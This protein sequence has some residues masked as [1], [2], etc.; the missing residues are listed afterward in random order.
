MAREAAG[1]S[2]P[3]LLIHSCSV[4][5]LGRKHGFFMAPVSLLVAMVLGLGAAA[6][7]AGKGEKLPERYRQWLVRDV[8]YIIT[9]EEKDAFLKLAGDEDREK[10][11][12]R[13]WDI[14]NPMPGSPYNSYKEEHYQ[15]IAYADQ[16]FGHEAGLEGW[17]TDRGRVYITLGPPQQTAYYTSL[18]KLRPVEI[19][20]YS[21]SHPSLPPFF[22]VMF[23]QRENIGDFRMYSPYFDGPEKLI[24]TGRAINDRV[25]ALHF[26][27]EAAGREVARIS[28]S[29]IPDEPADLK[30]ATSSL[31]SDVLLSTIRNLAN[32]PLEKAELER[33]RQL[34]ESVST[35][36]ILEGQ[37]LDVLTVPLRDS[38][39]LTRCHYLL[40]LRNPQDLSVG[41]TNDGRYSFSIE[42]RVRVFGP[43]NKLIFAQ[44]KSLSQTFDRS[45]LEQVKDK[46][47]GYE[48]W[49]PLPPGKYRLD[50]L[51]T[52]WLR[53]AGYHTEKDVVVPELPSE[54]MSVPGVLPF[55]SAETVDPAKADLL[56]FTM[57]G[58]KFTPL[59]GP[60]LV[61]SPGQ[62]LNLAYQ[63]WAPPK[64]PRS[65]QGQKL[66]V[67]YAF[68]RPASRGDIKV[69]RDAVDKEQFDA[70][71]SLV[72]G[73]KVS[74]EDLPA[75]NYL[76]TVTV[77]DPGSQQKAHGSLNFR[78]VATPAFV[79]AWDIYDETISEDVRKG[80]TDEQRALCYLY[81]G[82]KAEA[83]KWFR[84]AIEKDPSNEQARARL[85]DL[86]FAR[87]DYAD[88]A[89]LY[90]NGITGRTQEQTL[91][92]VAASLDKLGQ[93]RSAAQLLESALQLQSAT[94]P[95]LL[96]L[97]SYY[98]RLG[99]DQKAA[100]FARKG[101][102]LA[103]P[104][105]TTDKP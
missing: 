10:F 96:S 7:A 98:R 12:Q 23:Y 3:A 68:G 51:L 95:V 65:Y 25:G 52:D 32:N 104:T 41:Q 46:V 87:E 17:R 40:R 84:R 71:G 81:L 1:P 101:E 35:R 22:Y 57:A 86:Y 64:D 89:A 100:E 14:R 38:R 49:L 79:P 83:E 30:T 74:L 93:T 53:K 60:E 19:W 15:R 31:Q 97:A 56:P 55:S 50:F 9:K 37:N 24:T 94:G 48:G 43:N 91:L 36:M 33:R 5:G 8:A 58:V 20:F 29:L 67:E 44:E 80:I 11:I 4:G 34:L 45:R 63:I 78:I 103:V 70:T 27:E 82:Q 73:K 102:S 2:S 13:F 77:G 18:Q 6:S 90:S 54:G 21:S 62:R 59:L 26:V 69:V 75:G 92:R 47:L 39:G 66:E 88:V 85:V 28:L 72:N 16:H 76:L 42:A 99:E 105:S 61:F